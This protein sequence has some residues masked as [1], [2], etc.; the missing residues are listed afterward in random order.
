M[1]SVT[2]LAVQWW[3]EHFS[4]SFAA[5]ALLIRATPDPRCTCR[6]QCA[7][8]TIDF[9]HTH[10]HELSSDHPETTT[11]GAKASGG[12]PAGLAGESDGNVYLGLD[13]GLITFTSS[14]FSEQQLRHDQLRGCRVDRVPV[15]RLLIQPVRHAADQ[16]SV[17][18][19]SWAA[20]SMHRY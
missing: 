11:N 7:P 8:R 2:V 14:T 9:W 19:H 18:V 16:A 12:A 13:L 3:P 17:A 10:F 1:Q 4:R 15:H 6:I 5:S 20:P